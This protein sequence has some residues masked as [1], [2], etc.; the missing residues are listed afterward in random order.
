MSLYVLPSIKYRE[1]CLCLLTTDCLLTTNLQ[2]EFGIS[3]PISQC[4]KI[5]YLLIRCITIYKWSLF[6]QCAIFIEHYNYSLYQEFGIKELK[7]FPCAQGVYSLAHWQAWRYILWIYLDGHKE[8][9]GNV[10]KQ[11][12]FSGVHQEWLH[13]KWFDWGL[14]G[15]IVHKVRKIWQHSRWRNQ[16]IKELM[17][18]LISGVYAKKGEGRRHY[19][20]QKGKGLTKQTHA[21]LISESVYHQADSAGPTEEF[22]TECDVVRCI[23]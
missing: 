16:G 2:V 8:Y 22:L 6:S 1:S 3:S 10:R 18:Y 14:D 4:L 9:N 11:C 21:W 20:A 12:N 19:T 5:H 13:L 17:K 7:D 15:C 23:F